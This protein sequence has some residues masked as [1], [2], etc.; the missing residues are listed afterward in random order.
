M[1][2]PVK[3]IELK[4][5]NLLFSWLMLLALAALAY[6]EAA[7]PWQKFSYALT[8]ALVILNLSLLVPAL[9]RK[10]S[11]LSFLLVAA[12]IT[13]SLAAM[14]YF[15]DSPPYWFWLWNFIPILLG[16]L[17]YGLSGGLFFLV[18]I[19]GNEVSLA[20]ANAYN[21]LSWLEL[22]W[23]NHLLLYLIILFYANYPGSGLSGKLQQ[24]QE[25]QRLE[26]LNKELKRKEKENLQFQEHLTNEIRSRE[27]LISLNQYLRPGLELKTILERLLEKLR[28]ILG[29]HAAGIYQSI[30]ELPTLELAASVGIY[31]QELHNQT[32]NLDIPALVIK[33]GKPVLITAPETDPRLAKILQAVK[34]KSAL[35]Y[36]LS[37]KD[38]TGCLCLWSMEKNKYQEKDYE[39]LQAIIT[40]AEYALKHGAE[41]GVPKE[42]LSRIYSP[43]KAALQLA[44]DI[45]IP[46]LR[47]SLRGYLKEIEK[48]IQDL[49]VKL[50]KKLTADS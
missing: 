7:P 38:Q 30:P 14:L 16:S 8:L 47:E 23:Y 32:S 6:F 26:T 42:I 4:K 9:R 5:E 46:A 2:K 35:Y 40:Q 24:T 25:C 19:A 41:L 3:I 34:I 1:E 48:R 20:L 36:P 13:L 39:L 28:D 17:G 15:N 12:A 43:L 45:E 10:L 27:L 44:E 29:F 22:P 18:L 31:E 11:S 33:T 49:E 37:I 50:Q 21:L